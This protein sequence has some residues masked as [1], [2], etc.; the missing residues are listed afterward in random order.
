MHTDPHPDPNPD[1]TGPKVIRAPQPPSTQL[2]GKDCAGQ[3]DA[4]QVNRETHACLSCLP[5]SR[6]TL[7]ER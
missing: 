4:G 5:V 3:T 6:T 7:G 2:S 1:P